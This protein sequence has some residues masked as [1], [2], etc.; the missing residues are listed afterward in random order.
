VYRVL[1]QGIGVEQAIAE[2]RALQ[3]NDPAYEARARDYIR[4]HAR[5]T[6]GVER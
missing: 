4:R 5:E 1:D 2:A 6:Q 3:M